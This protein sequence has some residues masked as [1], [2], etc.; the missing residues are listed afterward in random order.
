MLDQSKPFDTSSFG[1]GND[2]SEM[3]SQSRPDGQ[4]DALTL[5]R[6]D[7]F[8]RTLGEMPTYGLSGNRVDEE[9][10]TILSQPKKV[11]FNC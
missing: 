5:N 9:A 4:K 1:N 10:N 6:E 11:T 2:F 7:E 3:L 8:C